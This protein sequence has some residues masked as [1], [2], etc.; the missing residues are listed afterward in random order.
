MVVG[1]AGPAALAGKRTSSQEEGPKTRVARP[2]AN[3]DVGHRRV[4]L[5]YGTDLF[6]PHGDPDDHFDLTTVFAMPELDVKAILLDRGKSQK[7]RPGRTPVEQ[8]F[9]LTG[10]RAPYAIGLGEKLRSPDDKGLNQ[11]AEY[12]G[13]IE[14]LFKTLRECPE[15]VVMVFTGSVRDVCAAFNREP[16]LLREKVSRLYINMGSLLEGQ[17]EWNEIVDPQA[18]IGLMRS[19]L[20]I[21]WCPCQPAENRGTFWKFKHEEVLE[22]VP[23]GLLNWFVYALQAP[24]TSELDPMEALAMDLRPWRRLVMHMVRGMWCTG[25]L[26]H[27]AGRTIYRVGDGWVAAASAPQGGGQPAEVFTFVPAYVEIA[28]VEGKAHTRWTEET[29]TPNMQVFK[30]TDP[31]YYEPALKSCLRDLLHH[32]PLAK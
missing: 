19:G 12:Q 15:P 27:A 23:L 3:I 32:F 11:P 16:E 28:D 29:S 18:Y 31:M 20:P 22:G 21:Y 1:L 26:I 4:P 25:P 6:H 13:A 10:R 14:L 24:L 17:E 30:V 7:S 9:R 5:V 8:M 2:V